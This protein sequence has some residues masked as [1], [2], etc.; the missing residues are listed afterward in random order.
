[1]SI[2]TIF[3][4]LLAL[5][6]SVTAGI[7][8]NGADEQAGPD[9]EVPAVAQEQEPV[10]RRERIL[11]ERGEQAEQQRA[12]AENLAPEALFSTS[13]HRG[14]AGLSY[15]KFDASLSNDDWD[16]SGQ[17]RKRW[18]F[19]GDGTWDT[20]LSSRSRENH[21]YPQPGTYQP[22]LLVQDASG[23]ADSI[24]GERVEIL[25]ECPPPDFALVDQNPNSP[26]RGE[27]FRL[28]DQRGHPLLIWFASPSK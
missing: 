17:L 20:P 16:L 4:T 8:C 24:V 19:D 26:T 15:I 22:R 2:Q 1:M 10:S 11:R 25:P 3:Y 5:F 23:L 21:V 27:T 7:G 28:S 12:V 13:P 18:D 9:A 14:W 6:L